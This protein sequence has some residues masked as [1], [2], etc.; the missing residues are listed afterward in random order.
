MRIVRRP[1]AAAISVTFT[2]AVAMAGCSFGESGTE[3]EPASQAEQQS[4]PRAEQEA[5]DAEQA[6]PP[7]DDSGSGGSKD[8]DV[9]E[10][11]AAVKLGE[12]AV[13]PVQ[14]GTEKQGVVSAKVTLEKGD[15]ADLEPLDLGDRAAGHVP[16]YVR[17]AFEKVEG[18]ELGY[19]S[20]NSDFHGM[21]PDGSR[22]A[23]L[24]I[25]GE[26][27]VCDNQTAP[28]E[29]DEGEAYESCRAFLVPEGTEVSEVAYEGR[30]S[31][32][33]D[34]PVTWSS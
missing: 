1:L 25:I 30:D 5:D 2:M 22:A 27:E 32:Y 19:G 3:D 9:T 21:T 7:A 26:W 28:A 20:Y 12:A 16:Y 13:V 31:A 34:D 33:E 18:K 23:P 15:P 24:S 10:P 4:E 29:F 11:G 14:S 6:D 8:A 17:I